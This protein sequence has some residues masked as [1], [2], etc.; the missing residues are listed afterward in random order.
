MTTTISTAFNHL[1]DASLEL[2]SVA[3]GN[4]EVL[5]QLRRLATVTAKFAKNMAQCQ[6]GAKFL[7]T[8]NK[9]RKLT[10]KLYAGSDEGSLVNL[11]NCI[12]CTQESLKTGVYKT[13]RP[14][15]IPTFAKTPVSV[16]QQFSKNFNHHIEL[17]CSDPNVAKKLQQYSKATLTELLA[18]IAKLEG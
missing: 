16:Y 3:N 18:Q 11:Y 12:L 4:P 8:K 5:K 1:E 2:A 9:V 17:T 6:E 15:D 10:K 7:G 14:C 13:F